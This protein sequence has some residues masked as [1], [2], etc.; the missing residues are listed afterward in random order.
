MRS[1]SFAVPDSTLPLIFKGLMLRNLSLTIYLRGLILKS[2][3][4]GPIQREE[5]PVSRFQG[6]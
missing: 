3:A 4:R 2:C 1:V 5:P 6:F